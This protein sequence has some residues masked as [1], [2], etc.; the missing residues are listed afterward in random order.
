MKTIVKIILTIIVFIVGILVVGGIKSA[1]G[2]EFS[3]VFRLVIGAGLMGGIYAIWK[4]DK[5]NTDGI[6]NTKLDKN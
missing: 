5:K 4:K 6:D 3:G 1:T 2:S